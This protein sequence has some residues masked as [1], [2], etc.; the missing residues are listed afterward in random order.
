[1][2]FP[3]IDHMI[4]I[5]HSQVQCPYIIDIVSVVLIAL[6]SLFLRQGGFSIGKRL[7]SCLL[8]I[9]DLETK[10]QNVKMNG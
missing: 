9:A 5:L 7:L 8:P 3:H 4:S 6:N 1:M 2:C 10:L